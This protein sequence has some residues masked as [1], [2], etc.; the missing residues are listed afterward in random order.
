MIEMLVNIVLI[1]LVLLSIGLCI[2]MPLLVFAAINDLKE[3]GS[4]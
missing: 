4:K 3:R 1:N 2:T